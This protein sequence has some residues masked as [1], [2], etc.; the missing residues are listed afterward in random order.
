MK[1]NESSVCS[2]HSPIQRKAF[3]WMWLETKIRAFSKVDGAR[4][5][6][7]QQLQQQQSEVSVTDQEAAQ[8][9]ARAMQERGAVPRPCDMTSRSTTPFN[10]LK[11]TVA[12]SSTRCLIRRLSFPCKII[13]LSFPALIAG[14]YQIEATVLKLSNSRLIPKNPDLR[15]HNA[16]FGF[17]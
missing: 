4:K 6:Q 11:R 14:V 1:E 9:A 12:V 10:P 2:I 5:H 17:V 15:S 16:T 7:R 8:C 13:R 3:R